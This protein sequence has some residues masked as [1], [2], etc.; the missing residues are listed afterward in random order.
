[1]NTINICRQ[2]G[3][4]YTAHRPTSKFDTTKCRVAYH[5]DMKGRIVVITQNKADENS[6]LEWFNDNKRR[7]VRKFTVTDTKFIID[8]DYWEELTGFRLSILDKRRHEVP[9]LIKNAE[10]MR[11]K[12]RKLEKKV[13]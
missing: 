3:K 6:M 4:R 7:I 11:N 1:M 9:K 8:F 13:A 10:Q 2:C 12:L 5:R